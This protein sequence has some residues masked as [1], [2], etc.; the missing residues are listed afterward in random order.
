MFKIGDRV[1]EKSTG[2]VG[3]IVGKEWSDA[4][5]I[6]WETGAHAGSKLWLEESYMAHA[7]VAGAQVYDVKQT[8]SKL[9]DMLADGKTKFTIEDL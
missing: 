7:T 4:W 6:M 9:V 5:N 3:V 2:D 1:V 8:I